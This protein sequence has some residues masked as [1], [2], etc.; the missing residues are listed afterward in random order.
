VE[1]RRSRPSR[2][3]AQVLVAM[4]A[5][6]CVVLAGR[7]AYDAGVTGVGYA[8]SPGQLASDRR[9]HQDFEKIRREFV[10]TVPPGS[11]VIIDP[12]LQHLWLQRFSEFTALAGGT[13]VT[14]R[15]EADYQASLVKRETSVGPRYGVELKAVD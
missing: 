13:L 2:H 7:G 15:R 9:L 3:L 6:L 8:R 11:R 14:D 5:L 10:T 1:L 12:P 4:L